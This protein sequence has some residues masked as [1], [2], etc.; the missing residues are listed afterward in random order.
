MRTAH[1]C[2]SGGKVWYPT[3]GCRTL[4]IPYP[5]DTLYPQILNPPPPDTIPLD[6]LNPPPLPEETWDLTSPERTWDQVPGLRKGPGT[7]DTYPTCEQTD[8]CENIPFP[9]LLLLAVNI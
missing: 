8:T 2:S 3:P 9:Q 6:I 1:F 5:V 7:R 4:L